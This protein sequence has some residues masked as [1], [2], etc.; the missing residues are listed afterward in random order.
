MNLAIDATNVKRR[1]ARK[2][3]VNACAQRVDVVKM[4]AALTFELLRTH[5]SECAAPALL[6]CY[7]AHRISQAP[8]N[9]KIGHF[10]LAALIHHQI[11]RLQITMDDLFVIVCVVQRIAELA[12]PVVQFGCLKD[13]VLLVAT[14]TREC[15]AIDV[16]HRN[17]ARAIVVHKVVNAHDVFVGEFQAT[18]RLALEIA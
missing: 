8:G 2:Q 6:H 17:A 15:V 13:F 1:L 18:S 16:F 7:H 14:Q 3:F 9:S 5:V 11:R 4:S 10:E 12:H